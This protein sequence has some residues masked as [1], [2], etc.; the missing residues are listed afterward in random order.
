M[1]TSLLAHLR[2]TYTKEEVDR[3]MLFTHFRSKFSVDRNV[4][5]LPSFGP[6][7]IGRHKMD[8]NVRILPSFGPNLIGRHKM[9]RNV[10]ILPSFGPNYLEEIKWPKCANFSPIPVH[11][12]RKIR[13]TEMCDLPYFGPNSI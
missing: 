12:L 3:D 10:R 13:W 7:L 1:T 4:R 9:D 8:R 11:I 6:N 5:I 2:I